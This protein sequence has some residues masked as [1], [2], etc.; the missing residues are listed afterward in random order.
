MW[1][2]DLLVRWSDRHVVLLSAGITMEWRVRGWEVGML[3]SSRK[4]ARHMD[5]Q[6]TELGYNQSIIFCHP[7]PDAHLPVAI[8]LRQMCQTLFWL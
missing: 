2:G 3:L 1:E 4:G 7:S 5:P 8:L 6:G